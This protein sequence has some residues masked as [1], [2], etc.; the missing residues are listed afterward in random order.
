MCNP[1][2]AILGAQA[3]GVGMS[4][5]GAIFGASAQKS[6]LKSQA[7]IDEINARIMDGNARAEIHRGNFLESVAKMKGSQLKSSQTA[8]FAHNGVDIAGSPSA[9]AVLTG[10]D[11]VTE[12]DANNIRANA[13]QAAWG[14]RFKAG[15]FRRHAAST[16]ATAAGISPFLAGATSLIEGAGQVASSWYSL[17]KAGGMSGQGSMGTPDI[18]GTMRNV[19]IDAQAQ[20]HSTLTAWGW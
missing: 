17:S 16:R 1:G 4:T 10:T 19:S 9:Q 18:S 15:D 8:R 7:R 2:A 5:V 11:V 13:L 14:Q 12:V 6:A 3:F 20:G